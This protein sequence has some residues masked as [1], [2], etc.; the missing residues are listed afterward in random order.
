MKKIFIKLIFDFAGR[1]VRRSG[2]TQARPV[3][4]C[5][6]N[7][8]VSTRRKDRLHLVSKNNNYYILQNLKNIICIIYFFIL[9]IL[10]LYFFCYSKITL[11]LISVKLFRIKFKLNFYQNVIKNLKFFFIPNLK[12]K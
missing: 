6:Q 3:S 9:I 7:L 2:K 11:H 12:V 8:V 10:V 5:H 1:R 4:V